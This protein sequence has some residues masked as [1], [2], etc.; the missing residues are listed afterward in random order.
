M[1]SVY[2]TDYI[3]E[4]SLEEGILGSHLSSELNESIKVLLVWHQNISS[5]YLDKFPNLVGVVRY[6]VGFDAIDLDEIKKR[7]LVFCNTPDYG[8]DEVSDTAL[9]MLL[10]IMRGVTKYN[11]SSRN[12]IDNWQENTIKCLRRA[13]ALTLGVIGAGRIGTALILKAKALKM[14]IMFYD[15]Y[16]DSG[17]EKAIGVERA[18]SLDDLL[19]QSD[20]ISIHTPLSNETRGMVN[21]E[22]INKMKKGASLINTARGEIIDDVDVL[23][24]A[25][26]EEKISNVAL[27]VLP[28]EPPVQCKFIQAWRDRESIVS[29]KIIINPHTAYYSMEAYDEMRI[30]AAQNVKIIL[31][32]GEPL[33]IIA[34]GRKT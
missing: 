24:H 2:I 22:F 6:G 12:Y 5:E 4:R 27:D 3:E 15:P 21:K 11:S 9:T 19:A 20:I 1:N 32:G 13:S 14:N 10:N 34:D 16:K 33:N 7:G 28:D 18:H 23:Y 17:Y 29:G 25:L 31:D 26:V 30:K 8:T